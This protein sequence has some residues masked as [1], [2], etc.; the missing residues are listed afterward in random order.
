MFLIYILENIYIFQKDVGSVYQTEGMYKIS[1]NKI[2]K[3]KIFKKDAWY[4]F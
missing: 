4:V 1:L 3:D 2:Q